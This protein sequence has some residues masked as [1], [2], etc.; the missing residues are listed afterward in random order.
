MYVY[1]F[2]T[3]IRQVSGNP[4]FTLPYWNYSTPDTSIRGVLP[5]Q[6]RL[7]GDPT[8][9]ALYVAD[10]NPGVNSGRPI[11]QGQPNDPL[12]L[13][14]LSECTYS[15]QGA[16]QGFCA[17][18]DFPLHGNI[19]VLVGTT[20]NMGNVPT[21]ANDPI[22]WAHHCNID[23]LWASWNAGGRQNPNDPTFLDKTFVF[24]DASGQRVVAKI[25]DFL[26]IAPL[27]YGYDRLEP[28]PRCP[29]VLSEA[30]PRTY[31]RTT[32]AVSLGSGPVKVTLA[33]PATAAAQPLAERIAALPANRHLYLVVRGLKANLQP[34]T[35]YHVYLELPDE[36]AGE[37][38]EHYLVGSLNFFDAAGHGDHGEHAAAGGS[39]GGGEGKFY[40]FDVTDLAR[41]L[42][43]AGKLGAEPSLTVLPGDQPEAEAQPVVGEMTLV[44]Q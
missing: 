25:S 3:I 44:E 11:Q 26:A 23:R 1:F 6:F 34:G 24:A 8:Y 5:P 30:T 43:A 4:A 35:L 33:A 27:G 9:G 19:H 14:A 31:N 40:S 37:H 38:R 18:L 21:A 13:S 12:S 41:E 39:S 10:R 42:A 16:R 7:P 32:S 28:V 17:R 22:F 2:E 29:V 15:P 36:A 20:T